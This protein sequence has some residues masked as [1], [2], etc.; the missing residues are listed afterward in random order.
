MSCL[1]Y[2][3]IHTHILPGYDDG[4]PDKETAFNMLRIAAENQT[5]YIIATPHF[6][7]GKSEVLPQS[8]SDSCNEL[9]SVA[10]EKGLDIKIY[11]GCEVF[12]SPELPDLYDAG[13]ISTLCNSDYILVELPM[14][15]VPPYTEPVLYKLQLKGLIP[16]LAHPERN[17]EIIVKPGILKEM[18]NRGILAQMNTGSLTGIYGKKVNRFARWLLS[19]GL[20]HF[21]A[22]DAH[23]TGA[24]RPD[25]SMAAG[26]VEKEYGKEMAD[27]LFIENGLAIIENRPVQAPESAHGRCGY[28]RLLGK[29]FSTLF[30]HRKNK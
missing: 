8:I 12:I 1:L 19:E 16:I 7:P 24:R 11:P 4:A 5:G 25:L 29:K 2:T 23:S 13:Y 30:R 22:S 17:M 15:S 28:I 6:I 20:V 10:N 18:I 9:Q 21:I 26:F 3:D 27:L 14:M